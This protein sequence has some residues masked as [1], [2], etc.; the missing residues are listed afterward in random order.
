MQRGAQKQE[1]AAA[2]SKNLNVRPVFQPSPPSQLSIL[3]LFQ[4]SQHK[5]GFRSAN[6]SPGVIADV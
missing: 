2:I 5:L 6:D 4:A 1:H 3:A